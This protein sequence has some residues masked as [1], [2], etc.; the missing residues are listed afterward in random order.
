MVCQNIC[1]LLHLR[2]GPIRMPC[3]KCSIFILDKNLSTYE[4]CAGDDEN[5]SVWLTGTP[6]FTI[7]PIALAF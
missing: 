2:V 7:L 4:R 3:P 5:T 1:L 6:L